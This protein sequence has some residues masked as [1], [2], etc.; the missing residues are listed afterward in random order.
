MLQ[1]KKSDLKPCY[2]NKR[3][4]AQQKMKCEITWVRYKWHFSKQKKRYKWVR[5]KKVYEDL[6]QKWDGKIESEKKNKKQLKL[7]RV[8]N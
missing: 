6:W 2:I 1:Q 3:E 7:A 8:S 4:P 5:E